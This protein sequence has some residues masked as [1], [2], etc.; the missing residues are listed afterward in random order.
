M[1]NM[2]PLDFTE[3]MLPLI[4]TGDTDR[5][6]DFGSCAYR[7]VAA[8]EL[9]ASQ[10]LTALKIAL[11][12]GD[13]IDNSKTVL[14]APRAR[15]WAE[16]EPPF[17]DLLRKAAVGENTPK[18]PYAVLNNTCAA[19]L[20]IIRD[21]A[22]RIFDETAP[23]DAPEDPDIEDI[24]QARS[25]L[26]FSLLGFGPTGKK[27]FTALGMTPPDAKKTKGKAA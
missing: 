18:A 6:A 23:L 10:L 3:A 8:A 27:L 4:S 26:H 20:P 13:K 5:D 11:F 9:A 15:F 19:W 24:V 21:V 22:M 17:Y 16:T 7:M 12:S 2:K 14:D 25:L 1:D